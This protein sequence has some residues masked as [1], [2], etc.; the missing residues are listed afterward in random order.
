MNGPTFGIVSLIPLALAAVLMG[1]GGSQAALKSPPP[2][3]EQRPQASDAAREAKE[4]AEAERI[5]REEA[6]R[7]AREAEEK[8]RV[9]AEATAREARTFENIYFD[10]DR[11]NIRDDQKPTLARHVER[12]KANPDFKV[13]IE[14]HCDERGTIE[15]NMALG[16][17]RA[18]SAK[19]FLVKTGIDAKQLTTI[20]YGK[21]RPVDP[22]H[23]ETA[24]ARNRRAE[25]K[26][27]E[28]SLP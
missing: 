4:R 22:G 8:A 12:L 3:P 18:D 21:E 26:V 24:W 16:Q 13:T 28:P 23:D 19:K 11:Y 2:A 9:E 25:F 5:A 14:G 6:E 10:Y 7:A 17:K 20:S 15:Y 1:C 27:T